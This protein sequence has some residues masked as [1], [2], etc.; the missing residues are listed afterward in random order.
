MTDLHGHTMR[1]VRVRSS[2][3]Q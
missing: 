1:A 2:Q 3:Q